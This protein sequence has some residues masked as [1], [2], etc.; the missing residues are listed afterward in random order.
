MK[1]LIAFLAVV[2]MLNFLSSSAIFAQEEE[3]VGTEVVNQA[4]QAAPVTVAEEVEEAEERGIHKEIKAKFIE[5]GAIF[6]SFVLLALIFGLAICIERIIYLNLAS[7]NT[8]K[9]LQDV[10]NA[11]QEGGVEAAKEVC[12]NTRGPVA[13]IFYQGLD[14]YDEGIEVIEKS[15]ISY[16]SVQMGLLEKGMTWISLFIA[17]APMLG[18]MGTVIGMIDAFDNIQAMGDIS[19][20]AVAGGIK[21]ALI[22]TVS[23]LIVAII[24]QVFYNYIVSKIDGIVNT[25]EDASIS[26]LDILVKYNT[27]K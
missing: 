17:I 27:K 23:G 4:A 12:R 13:S 24:L 10:E 25:M 3:T 18:F 8:K 26:L 14:R 9:L 1:K 15:V 16:G 2:G 19:A 5:G 21:I 22:T 6:M 11:L 20:G 7:T